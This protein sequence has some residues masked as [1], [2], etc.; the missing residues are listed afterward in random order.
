MKCPYCLGETKV[1]DK[2]EGKDSCTRR[3]RECLKCKRR[4]TT[5]ERIETQLVVIKKDGRRQAYDREKVK[6]G[7]LRACEK[8]PV[9]QDKID[10]LINEVEV[11][12]K[13]HD[14]SEVPSKFIGEM[15]MKRLKK[16]DPVAYVRF[17]SVYKDFKD[18]SEF[19]KALKELKK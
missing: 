3:R 5:H 15:I 17:A 18:V 16:L 2:R 7:V 11:K 13:S 10:S 12:I 14:K 4:F 1:L 8:R 6:N 9:S 19:K